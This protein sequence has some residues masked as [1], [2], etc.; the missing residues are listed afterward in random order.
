LPS[1]KPETVLHELA[2]LNHIDAYRYEHPFIPTLIDTGST[3]I[4]FDTGLGAPEAP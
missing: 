2:A 1:D 4:L 3:R